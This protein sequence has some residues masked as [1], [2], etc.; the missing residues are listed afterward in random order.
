MLKFR[1]KTTRNGIELKRDIP[2]WL[3]LLILFVVFLA[4]VGVWGYG[5]YHLITR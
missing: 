3:G 4:T 1:L 5:M 2:N